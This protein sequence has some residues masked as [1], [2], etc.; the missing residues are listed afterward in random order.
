MTKSIFISYNHNS[1]PEESTALRLQTISNLYG[2]SVSLPYRLRNT[3]S[4]TNETQT[5][6]ENSSFVVAFCVD[7][8]TKLLKEELS[9]A[10]SKKK[11]LIVIYDSAKGKKINFKDNVNV[12]EVFVDFTKTDDALHKIAEFLRTSLAASTTKKTT[13]KTQNEDSGLGI[14]LLGIGLGLLAAWALSKDK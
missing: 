1:Q 11:P 5:R 12:K 3:S 7:G 9:Y 13:K 8:L 6:I 4:I 10:I 2:L 14:A